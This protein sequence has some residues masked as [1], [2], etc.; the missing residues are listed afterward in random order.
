M[1]ARRVINVTVDVIRDLP[2]SVL[3]CVSGEQR[4]VTIG[5]SLISNLVIVKGKNGLIATMTIPY[6]LASKEHLI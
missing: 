5:K 4:T 3:V 6:W 2:M 1:R